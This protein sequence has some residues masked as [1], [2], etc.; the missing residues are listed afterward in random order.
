MINYLI[1]YIS[2]SIYKTS[3]DLNIKTALDENL[4]LTFNYLGGQVASRKFFT[5]T[6]D[7]IEANLDYRFLS[8][9]KFSPVIKIGF[10]ITQCRLIDK[11]K[12]NDYKISK[13]LPHFVSGIGI[14]YLV[15]RS[16]GINLMIDNHYYFDDKLD[17]LKLG[18]YNDYYWGG[19]L[20]FMFY[21]SL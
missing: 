10:G 6:I 19:R 7:N 8:Q 2:N 11:T 20:G 14:E 18:E 3:G 4:A 9:S 12:N 5:S 17:G 15:S 16:F 1:I 13:W 21:F